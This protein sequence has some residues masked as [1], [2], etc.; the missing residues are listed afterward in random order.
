M[1]EDGLSS[2][3]AEIRIHLAPTFTKSE[4][5]KLVSLGLHERLYQEKIPATIHQINERGKEIIE[6][7]PA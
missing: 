2:D 6:S 4:P 5:L 7:N 3:L 1:Q